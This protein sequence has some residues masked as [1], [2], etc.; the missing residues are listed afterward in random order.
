MHSNTKPVERMNGAAPLAE[1]PGNPAA[2]PLV[3]PN[4]HSTAHLDA[5]E[6]EQACA[7]LDTAIDSM[8]VVL[9]AAL[10]AMTTLGQMRALL[11]RSDEGR[12]GAASAQR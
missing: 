7:A 8:G 4:L 2:R 5:H 11:D 6:R 10:A 12:G 3:A 9:E 1:R